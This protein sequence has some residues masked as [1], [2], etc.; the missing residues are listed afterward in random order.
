M[1]KSCVKAYVAFVLVFLIISSLVAMDIAISSMSSREG[2]FISQQGAFY[3]SLDANRRIDEAVTVG[4]AGGISAYLAYLTTK[5]TLEIIGSAGLLTPEAVV[6][7]VEGSLDINEMKRWSNTG[8]V[9]AL[10]IMKSRNE[11]SPN[12]RGFYCT[13]ATD[14]EIND[15]MN[16]TLMDKTL[17]LPPQTLGLNLGNCYM[18]PQTSIT[19]SAEMD[20]DDMSSGNLTGLGIEVSLYDEES[21]EN[22]YRRGRIAHLYY[23]EENGIAGLVEFPPERAIKVLAVDEN[24]IRDFTGNSYGWETVL[25]DRYNATINETILYQALFENQ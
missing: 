9:V 16:A 17:Y 20:I 21:A 8:V 25:K 4:S 2:S 3:S 14:E 6:E 5:A 12:G 11:A 19:P 18:V 7:A 13:W 22:G 10:D 15:A 24:A 23:D 1:Q